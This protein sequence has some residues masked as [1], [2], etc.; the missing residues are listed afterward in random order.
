M[1][2]SVLAIEMF[3]MY[4]DLHVFIRN[5]V[6]CVNSSYINK[7]DSVVLI[8]YI[9]LICSLAMYFGSKAK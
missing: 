2:S 9:D 6:P 5:V 4:I 1:Y 7:C 3:I 8:V